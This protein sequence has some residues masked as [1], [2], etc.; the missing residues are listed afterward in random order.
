MYSFC[1]IFLRTCFA[2]SHFVWVW[3]SSYPYIVLHRDMVFA[4]D[5][6]DEAFD[7]FDA[8][9]CVY[10]RRLASRITAHCAYL[11]EF[12]GGCDGGC[13][14][15]GVGVDGGPVDVL[16]DGRGGDRNGGPVDDRDGG[17]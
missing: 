7:L 12:V 8:V 9:S 15:S 10:L 1:V 11:R 6:A 14:Y 3:S 2:I 4:M 13:R 5:D 16:L 17:V